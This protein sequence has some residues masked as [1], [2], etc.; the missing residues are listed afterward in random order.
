MNEYDVYYTDSLRVTAESVSDAE[1]KAIN[2]IRAWR[3]PTIA[4]VDPDAMR[5]VRVTTIQQIL[6]TP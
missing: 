6:E 1:Q 4:W 3:H 2:R 5:N